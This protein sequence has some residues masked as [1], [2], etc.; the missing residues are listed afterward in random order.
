MQTLEK[1]DDVCSEYEELCRRFN[2]VNDAYRSVS[3]RSDP[4]Y[5]SY[6]ASAVSKPRVVNLTTRVSMQDP[7]PTYL[8]KRC[9]PPLLWLHAEYQRLNV[10]PAI[11]SELL[12]YHELH[13]DEPAVG[14]PCLATGSILNLLGN[15][16]VAIV[17]RHDWGVFLSIRWHD[18]EW[19]PFHGFLVV[20]L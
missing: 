17:E 9:G 14:R 20:D 18:A 12:E 7:D 10:R 19:D 8:R 6:K 1:D 2:R 11:F 5:G 15:H 16:M 13:L 4:R 3:I